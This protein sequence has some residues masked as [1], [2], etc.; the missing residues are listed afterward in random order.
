MRDAGWGEQRGLAQSVANVQLRSHAQATLSLR[1][2]RV[3]APAT[4]CSGS[5]D[6]QELRCEAQ[7]VRGYRRLEWIDLAAIARLPACSAFR[8][9]PA[10]MEHAN[11]R[12]PRS[13]QPE[14]SGAVTQTYSDYAIMVLPHLAQR[15]SSLGRMH[16]TRNEKLPTLRGRKPGP[17][18][19][20][21]GQHPPLRQDVTSVGLDTHC[22]NAARCGCGFLIG[23][24]IPLGQQGK[25]ETSRA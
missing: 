20:F 13:G 14:N 19:A 24:V 18:P 17:E 12:T 22:T 16:P 8:K 1:A 9:S 5:G 23:G 15:R 4:C 11:R 6:A 2:Y 21:P 25:V 10:T 3:L 7:V